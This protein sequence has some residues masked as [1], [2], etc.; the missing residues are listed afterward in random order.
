MKENIRTRLNQIE[1]RHEEIALLLS[2]PEVMSDQNQYRDLSREYSTLEPVVGT[3]KQWQANKD[4][5]EE[6]KQMLGD[7]DPAM[8][9]MAEEELSSTRESLGLLEKDL[10][11]LLERQEFRRKY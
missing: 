2:Q 6:A 8:K 7:S 5:E 4:S 11:L 1:A 10:K 3:W 9:K